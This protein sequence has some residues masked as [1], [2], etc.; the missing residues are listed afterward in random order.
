MYLLKPLVSKVLKDGTTKGSFICKQFIC[1]VEKDFLKI[2]A[3]FSLKNDNKGPFS[4]GFHKVLEQQQEII[5]RLAKLFSNLTIILF[6]QFVVNGM[7]NLKY[8]ML[9]FIVR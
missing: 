5:I 3:L 6:K 4:A 9:L 8:Q 1:Y 7:V 2:P